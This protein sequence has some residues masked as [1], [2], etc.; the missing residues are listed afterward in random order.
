MLIVSKKKSR[1]LVGRREVLERV[2]LT[3][4]TIWKMMQAGT[5]PRSRE[6]G[7]KVAW[8]ES[9]IDAWIASRPIVKLKGDAI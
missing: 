6:I 5:F 2:P 4:V 8:L 9:E 1:K 7:G 3:Y